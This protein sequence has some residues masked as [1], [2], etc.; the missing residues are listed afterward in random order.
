MNEKQPQTAE[1]IAPDQAEELQALSG[2]PAA[3]TQAVQT[4]E[5]RRKALRT[6][7]PRKRG[8]SVTIAPGDPAT[9]DVFDTP[10]SRL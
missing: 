1:G 7:P 2:Q 3:K 5:E 9:P 8:P 4:E 6:P 10:P